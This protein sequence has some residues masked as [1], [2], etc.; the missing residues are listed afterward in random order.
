MTSP[1]EQDYCG[2]F[3]NNLSC[4]YTSFPV[5]RALSRARAMFCCSSRCSSRFFELRSSNTPITDFVC[6][7][8]E[9]TSLVRCRSMRELAQPLLFSRS[10]KT[11]YVTTMESNS[12]DA[13][14]M[15]MRCGIVS[16]SARNA[17]CTARSTRDLTCLSTPKTISETIHEHRPDARG[18]GAMSAWFSCSHTHYG[19]SC[20]VRTENCL[21]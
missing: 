8:K 14:P 15:A 19:F 18:V 7:P 12:T 2:L 21:I 11:L 17:R 3:E 13:M 1:N 20:L 5:V 16:G 4:G 6:A 9:T 10:N